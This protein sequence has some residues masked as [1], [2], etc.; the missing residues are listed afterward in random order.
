M[1]V[2][3]CACVCISVF[4]CVCVSVS[5]VSVCVCVHV[6]VCVHAP[7]HPHPGCRAAAVLGLQDWGTEGCFLALWLGR[8]S[9]LFSP[10]ACSCVLLQMVLSREVRVLWERFTV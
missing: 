2:H 10:R 1:C 7:P 5:Y 3:V 8:L 4:V 9:F 6:R